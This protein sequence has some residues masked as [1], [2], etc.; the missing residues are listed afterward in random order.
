M[1][2]PTAINERNDSCVDPFRRNFILGSRSSLS[3]S[4]LA[5]LQDERRALLQEEEKGEEERRKRIARF[6]AR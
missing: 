5:A 1:C 3:F 4:L 6:K 2:L